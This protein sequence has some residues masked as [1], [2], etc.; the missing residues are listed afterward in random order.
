MAGAVGQAGER[1]PTGTTGNTG[2]PGQ[3]GI[4]GIQ[5]IQGPTGNTGNPGQQGIQ[6]NQGIQG[7]QGPTGN[8]GN[9]GS[10]GNTGQGVPVGGAAGTYL[11]KNSTTD[12][13]TVWASVSGAGGSTY[14]GDLGPKGVT[15]DII[16][17]KNGGWTLTKPNTISMPLPVLP[18]SSQ[19][20]G[21]TY[22]S[23]NGNSLPV[24]L[25]DGTFLVYNMA[26]TDL[27]AASNSALG[28][29]GYVFGVD[30]TGF[31]KDYLSGAIYGP[32]F[33]M[34]I[35]QGV[36]VT[37]PSG[38]FYNG[39]GSR[40]WGTLVGSK[41]SGQGDANTRIHTGWAIKLSGVTSGGL[42]G[43]GGIQPF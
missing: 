30:N 16:A 40:N 43:G 37:Y 8:T 13:D 12:Y 1:G 23:C 17:I 39:S 35:R 18:F 26:Y 14:I 33:E 42:G 38:I 27:N 3:Q 31:N 32:L 21:V 4:Q 20:G 7:I 34:S 29:N 36:G 15:A 2:N 9:R 28:Y 24:T 5:G 25:G 41:D 11:K 19:I 6:G 10:T 22:W